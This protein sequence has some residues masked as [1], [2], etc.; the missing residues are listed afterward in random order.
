[1]FF[2]VDQG[3]GEVG[4]FVSEKFGDFEASGFGFV[5]GKGG[6]LGD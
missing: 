5:A 2:V 4:A 3:V 1:V 6:V